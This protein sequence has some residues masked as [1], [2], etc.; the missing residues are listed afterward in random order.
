MKYGYA[1]VS[2]IGQDLEGQIDELKRS[3]A[4]EVYSEHFTGTKVDRPQF[5]KLLSILET[6]DELIVTKLDRFSRSVSDGLDVIKELSAKGIVVNV[7]NIGRLDDTPT[8]KLML[9]VFFAFAEF[10]RD[11][12]V[13][14][15]QEGKAYARQHNP[16]YKDGRP[17]RKI[18][19]RYQAAYDYLMDGHTYRETE[20]MTGLSRA[21]LNRIRKQIEED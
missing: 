4:E 11:M 8:G 5:Q 14:R 12:I 13:Q 10:E 1:R 6:G 3:G 2:T 17:R 7:L 18:T 19:P 16:S 20:N 21:T 9:S 15:T